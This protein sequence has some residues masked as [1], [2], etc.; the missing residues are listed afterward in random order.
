MGQRNWAQERGYKKSPREGTSLS[1][2]DCGVL[3]FLTFFQAFYFISFIGFLLLSF[4]FSVNTFFTPSQCP[5]CVLVAFLGLF[6][7][8]TCIAEQ[9][10]FFTTENE[11]L[12]TPKTIQHFLTHAGKQKTQWKTA[13]E[14]IKHSP[15]C[16]SEKPTAIISR[17]WH[18][19]A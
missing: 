18:M 9:T 10:T 6:R 8:Q 11:T 19:G 16:A 17:S 12:S 14:S 1:R 13:R 5:V 4:L 2:D 7:R 3:T 15:N